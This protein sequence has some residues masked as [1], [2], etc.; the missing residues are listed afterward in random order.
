MG[1]TFGAFDFT[2]YLRRHWLMP[3]LSVAAAVVLAL[4]ASILLPTRYT[5]TASIMI[6]P[7]GMSDTR[8]ATAVSP[9][10]LESL[11]SYES[12]ASSDSLFARAVTRFHL[13]DSPEKPPIES[14]KK[15]VLK[16]SKIRDTKILEISV[17]LSSP[18]LA[19][20]CAQFLAEETV[21]LNRDANA[22]SDQDLL[23]GAS[24]QLAQAQ[25][26]FDRAR[27]AMT[28]ASSGQ[29]IE[30]L[31]ADVDSSVE[32]LAKLRSG[33]ADATA[34]GG[35]GNARAAALKSQIAELQRDFDKKSAGLSK[36]AARKEEAQS[37]LES[38]QF[39]YTAAFNRTTDLKAGEGSR[40]ER[41]RII[42]PGIVPQRP[43]SPNIPLNLLVAF[44]IALTAALAYS[45]TGFAYERK[46][47]GR[48]SASM[49]SRR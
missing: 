45:A 3:V 43:S 49:A 20:R 26:R 25:E 35:D 37:E 42:D 7:P 21:K 28:E 39:A 17:T 4:M 22:A 11:K 14:L 15:R 19:Q 5:A 24:R 33:L 8:T 16:V 38:A 6:D 30:A 31:Q 23:E 12:F 41:L 36:L 32:V 13:Q 1:E 34:A 9:V 18:V 40:G 27:K 48:L 10:Y 29:D 44:V 2:D 46:E 47:M